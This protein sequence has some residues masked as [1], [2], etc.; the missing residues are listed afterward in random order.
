[1]LRRL[2]EGAMG[3][4]YAAKD[5]FLR[6]RVAFKRMNQA[7]AKSP[8]LAARFLKEAQITAQLEHPNIIPIYGLE[9]T[10]D[11]SVGYAMKFIEGQTL[12]DLIETARAEVAKGSAANELANMANR[13]RIFTRIC[14]AIAYAHAK[15]VLH[16]DL[17]PDNI[18]IGRFNQVYVVD[19]GICRIMH[20]EEE[21]T[22]TGGPV[23]AQVQQSTQ[24]GS[25][26]GTPAYMSPEQ[27]AGRNS[28]LDGRSDMYSLGLILFEI[29]SLRQAVIGESVQDVLVKAVQGQ[30]LPLV[31]VD[32]RV[33]IPSELRAIISK[34]TALLPK[35]R[36]ASISEFTADLRRYRN[37]EAVA[38]L[39]DTWLLQVMR[40]ISRNRGATLAAVVFLLL[41]G[42]G[43]ILTLQ[44]RHAAQVAKE[45]RHRQRLQSLMLSVSQHGH[46]IDNQ[47][48]DYE[49]LLHELVGRTVEALTRGERTSNTDDAS[50][51]T[52]KPSAR[53]KTTKPAKKARRTPHDQESPQ[54]ETETKGIFFNEDFGSPSRGP[55]DLADSDRYGQK[56]S[57]NYPVFKLPMQVSPESVRG[58]LTTLSSLRKSFRAT[59]DRSHLGLFR[60]FI[61]LTSGVHL[62]YPGRGGFP[63]AY[64]GRDRPKYKLAQ[65]QRELRWGNVYLDIFDEPLIACSFPLYSDTDKF[66]GVAG[67][68]LLLPELAE[69]LLALPNVPAVRKVMLVDPKGR[70]GTSWPDGTGVS[71]REGAV[72]TLHRNQTL[73]LKPLSYPDVITALQ[74]EPTGGLRELGREVVVHYPISSLGW[75]LVVVADRVALLQPRP[76]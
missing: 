55:S 46:K 1:M 30:K 45:R 67:V 34:A 8:A 11:G 54:A 74:D 26:I 58:E 56:I 14:D 23:D 75:F 52:G 27:A 38:A 72:G 63:A 7:V 9:S 2:G 33:R 39:P 19:W 43:G 59:Y 6:R 32:P 60:L 15:S 76:R 24:Y 36:Y 64:D 50:A 17:K 25:V 53:N 48:H 65:N 5:S 47:L 4:V 28:E 40:W 51:N 22:D 12:T 3:E 49:A 18:M 20:A 62:A 10:A 69:S 42:L 21:A 37:G 73:N 71:R 41:M 61:T 57:L 29:V 16:R 44:L 70:I 68:D 31:H 35:D 66:L 13:L